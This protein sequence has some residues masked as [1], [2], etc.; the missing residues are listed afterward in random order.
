MSNMS[1]ISE[2]DSRIDE[3][4]VNVAAALSCGRENERVFP[5]K[6]G[7]KEPLTKHGFKDATSD[8]GQICEWW[9]KWPGANIGL[10][11]GF[12][13]DTGRGFAVLDV[14]RHGEV[15]GFATLAAL[16]AEQGELPE[17]ATA[18]TG[19]EGKHYYLAIEGPTPTGPIGPGLEL[20]ADGGYVV[21]PPSIHPN[22]RA[23]RWE[24][25]PNGRFGPLPGWLATR[26][27]RERAAPVA[28]RIEEGERRPTLTSLAGTM[29][30]RGMGEAEIAAAL[31]VTNAERCSPPLDEAAVLAIATSVATLYEPARAERPANRHT[32]AKPTLAELIYSAG[33]LMTRTFEEPRWAIPGLLPEGLS[34]LAGKPKLGKSWLALDFALSIATGRPVLGIAPE[35]GD[36]L[37]LALEDN[38]RR[39]Q[40]RAHKLFPPVEGQSGWDAD[41]GTFSVDF[42]GL[43]RPTRLDLTNR[44]PRLDEGGLEYLNE[45]CDLHPLRR[46]IVVDTLIRIKPKGGRGNAYEEDAAALGPLQALALDRNVALLVLSH[47]RKPGTGRGA[48]ADDPLDS[49]TGSLGIAGTLDGALILQRERGQADAMLYL[50]GRDIENEREIPMSWNNATARWSMSG[51]AAEARLTDERSAVYR[52]LQEAGERISAQTVADVLGKPRSTTKGLLMKLVRDG[53]IDSTKSGYA[54]VAIHADQ[55]AHAIPTVH[56]IHIGEPG[57]PPSRPLPGLPPELNAFSKKGGAS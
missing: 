20:K 37:Y 30:R 26:T 2:P 29:R 25:A 22:G 24:T 55:A 11:T 43:T 21:L 54:V 8:E 51:S 46:L 36:V 16:V 13:P 56:A 28:D 52:V 39:L 57:D 27:K 5:L 45:W 42:T 15:D 14:D 38:P 40:T 47:L 18:V 50:T 3:G 41:A 33:D 35:Q 4:N 49:I 10:R 12:D 53:L 1:A 48:V 6:A 34:M 31:L 7:G 19:G 32:G 23:Y 9:A 17:T 44:W